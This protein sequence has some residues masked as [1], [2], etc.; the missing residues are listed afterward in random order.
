MIKMKVNERIIEV[1][2]DG[3]KRSISLVYGIM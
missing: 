2:M 1:M 3:Y